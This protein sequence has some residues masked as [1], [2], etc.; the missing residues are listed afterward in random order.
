MPSSFMKPWALIC[1]ILALA[2]GAGPVT[3]GD[4]ETSLSDARAR[5]ILQES[6]DRIAAAKS[7][8]FRIETAF[9]VVQSS[10]QSLEFGD[11]RTVSLRRPNRL[12]VDIERRE[13]DRVQLTFDGQDGLLYSADQSAY[14]KVALGSTVDAA[15][16]KLTGEL[17]VPFPLAE[18]LREDMNERVPA[19][20]ES[21][22]YVG[23][24]TLD[25]VRCEQVAYEG[26]EADVQ[27]WVAADDPRLPRRIV[28]TYH[29]E[30]GSPQFRADF[31]E[32]D[33]EPDVPDALFAF[34]PPA[35]TQELSFARLA[36]PDEEGE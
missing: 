22:L 10:G 9:D 31:V 35:G 30:R 2:S 16:D 20:M 21:A 28:V 32:W 8:R 1:A 36:G 15:L 17:G 23:P 14:A 33:L 12:R 4:E 13:G 27:V 11:Q 26:A 3:A 34:T 19:R 7:L 24:A 6:L 25:G 18:L 5:A 29:R